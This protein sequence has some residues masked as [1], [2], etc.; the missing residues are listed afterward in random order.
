MK[1]LILFTAA[2]ILAHATANAETV[3]AQLTGVDAHI[4]KVQLT[5][6]GVLNVTLA[7]KVEETLAISNA[8]AK[9]LLQDAQMLATADLVTEHRDIICQLAFPMGHVFQSLSVLNSQTGELTLTLSS[10]SCVLTSYTHPKYSYQVEQAEQL[11]T[12]LATL[13]RQLE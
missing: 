12:K 4:Q 13:A 7:N 1:K 2:A 5:E 10:N 11:E 9:E 3:V 8:N 6:A